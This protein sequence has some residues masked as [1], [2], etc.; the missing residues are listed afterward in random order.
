MPIGN[1]MITSWNFYPD[2]AFGPL[3]WGFEGFLLSDLSI[4]AWYF[5]TIGTSIR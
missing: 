5:R 4:L 1:E 3:C 2:L